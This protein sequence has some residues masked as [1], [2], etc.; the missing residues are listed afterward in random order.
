[1]QQDE[2]KELTKILK[3]ILGIIVVIV[4][5]FIILFIFASNYV[6]QNKGLTAPF[7]LLLTLQ[8]QSPE[9]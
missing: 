9:G 7:I 2:T 8:K 3:I 6:Q 1:M 5:A 4:I